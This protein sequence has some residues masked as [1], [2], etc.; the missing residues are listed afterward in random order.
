MKSIKNPFHLLNVAVLSK[1]FWSF[2]ST[3][4]EWLK[5]RHSLK[6]W[7]L[8]ILF[9]TENQINMISSIFRKR[10]FG[11]KSLHS[12]TSV[13]CLVTSQWNTWPH[14]LL[15]SSIREKEMNRWEIK[16]AAEQRIWQNMQQFIGGWIKI[17]RTSLE[18]DYKNDSKF[19]SYR[20]W[21]SLWSFLIRLGTT[22]IIAFSNYLVCT[23]K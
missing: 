21:G 11:L 3:V 12:Y 15:V 23:E 10:H 19:P 5:M 4:A 9:F 17:W 16:G 6:T 22:G 8:V 7:H 2:W 20:Y 1:V 13:F 14:I 18:R